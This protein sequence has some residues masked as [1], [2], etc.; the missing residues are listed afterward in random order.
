[1]AYKILLV[2]DD[3]ILLGV[4]STFLINEG[5][6]VATAVNGEIALDLLRKEKFD[7]LITDV[8]M[9]GMSG[10]QLIKQVRQIQ[11]QLPSVIVSGLASVSEAAE[12]VNLRVFHFLRKPIPDLNEL[13]RVA[14]EAIY[15]FS[16]EGK[17]PPAP[18]PDA[19]SIPEAVKRTL[20]DTYLKPRFGIF[21]TG[22]AHNVNSPL[23]GVMG[24]AQLT[25]MKNP[26]LT[27]LDTIADQA[28]K[29][30]AMLAL[31][32]DKG[33]QENNRKISTVNLKTLIEREAE[34]LNFNL[35]YKHNVDKKY[36]L[37]NVP[38]FNAVPAH[39][40]QIFNQLLQNALDA[41]YNT[42]EKKILIKL[43]RKD[44]YIYWIFKDSGFGIAPEDL[45]KIFDPGFSSKP[46]PD[47][48]EDPEMPCGYGMGLYIVKEILKFYS[49]DIDVQSKLGK[50][51]TVT[52]TLPI[53]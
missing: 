30:S 42:K 45:N 18:A 44:D 52:I 11:P 17:I 48:I 53:V 22:M 24:Y 23:G 33:H 28:A 35:F 14:L 38:S 31:M 26:G 25:A 27:G 8:K 2:D 7:L 51:A 3:E 16:P 34:V 36:E 37:E 6:E 46:L 12:A 1:L 10:I 15:F 13:K 9:P 5:L 32:A 43:Y 4:Y 40:A 47:Q 29:A 50:G 20:I 21:V 41:V 19:A 49:G 39:F